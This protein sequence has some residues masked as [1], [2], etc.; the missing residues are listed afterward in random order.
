MITIA[1]LTGIIIIILVALF[2]WW[3]AWEI[4]WLLGVITTLTIIIIIM[5]GFGVW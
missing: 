2:I 1:E 5:K 3:A 4:H